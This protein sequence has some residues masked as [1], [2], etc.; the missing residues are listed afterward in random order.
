MQ[1]IHNFLK[2]FPLKNYQPAIEKW[3]TE[4]AEENLFNEGKKI[5]GG[6]ANPSLK[7]VE[8]RK[9]DLT[10]RIQLLNQVGI[11]ILSLELRTDLA[12]IKASERAKAPDSR[13]HAAAQGRIILH[14]E[15]RKAVR[16]IVDWVYGK[17]LNYDD[18]E[19]L[20]KLYSL[21]VHLDILDLA[22]SCLSILSS[23][24]TSCLQRA[25]ANDV[26]LLELL[27]SSNGNTAAQ[28]A[29]DR[30]RDIV[31]VIFRYVFSSARPPKALEDIVIGSM[32]ERS[33][34][35]V[36]K[37]FKAKVNNRFK[38]L[39]VEALY[40]QL[41]LLYKTLDSIKVEHNASELQNQNEEQVDGPSHDEHN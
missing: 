17:Q 10:K 1:L 30:L 26:S 32:S 11:R 21:A 15:D 24:A 16:S 39:L 35:L 36:F 13:V 40:K 33:D 22:Q 19:H 23:S 14:N 27:R 6:L 41:G 31:P 5:Q 8:F 18:A 4:F 12:E 37:I 25:S 38:D 28:D 2:Q 9:L 3:L 34:P 29:G 20:C 7:K